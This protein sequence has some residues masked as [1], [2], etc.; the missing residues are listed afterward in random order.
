MRTKNHTHTHTHTPKSNGH[1]DLVQ[2]RS[3]QSDHETGH[4]FGWPT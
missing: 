4:P 2:P 3:A 1:F